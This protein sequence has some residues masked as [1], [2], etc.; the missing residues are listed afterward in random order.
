M[1]WKAS[2]VVCRTPRFPA[3]SLRDVRLDY[4]GLLRYLL[5][6]IDITNS[7]N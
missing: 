2:V 4:R 1:F 3:Q 6:Y 5:S 7:T